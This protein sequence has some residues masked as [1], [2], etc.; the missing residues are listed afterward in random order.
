MIQFL[1]PILLAG[2]AAVVVPVVL[3]LLS[4]SRFR[5]VEWGAMRFLPGGE[6]KRRQ[7]SRLQQWGLLS[8]RI[9]LIGIL[10][11]TLALPVVR[12]GRAPRQPELAEIILDH[13][14]SM[15]LI[16]NDRSRLDRAKEAALNLLAGLG[17]NDRA[18]LI[19]TG[20][21]DDPP[22]RATEDLQSIAQ[23]IS[24]LGLGR[25]IA[26]LNVAL[27]Q[28][29]RLAVADPDRNSKIFIISDRQA[30]SWRGIDNKFAEHWR[31]EFGKSAP[32]PMLWIPVGG[33]GAENVAIDS[34]RLLDPPAIASLP[35]RIEAR[36]HN[37]GKTARGPIHLRLMD[38][39]VQLSQ[40]ELTLEPGESR[41]IMLA[42]RFAKPTPA[43]LAATIDTNDLS[44]DNT[45]KCALQVVPRIP[46]LII[47]GDQKSGA[48]RS[49]ADFLRLALQPFGAAENPKSKTSDAAGNPCVV[50]IIS[51]DQWPTTSLNDYRV[52]VLANVPTFPAEQVRALEQYAYAGGGV[53]IAPGNLVR[54]DD[55][56]QILY[57]NGT[58]ILPAMLQPPTSIDAPPTTLLGI[59]LSH[60]IFRFLRGS[61]DPL[62]Q[63]SIARYFPASPNGGD[64]RVL[65][66]YAT[67]LPFLVEGSF[68][69]GH[70][71]LVTTPLD[72]NWS[73]LPLS[74]FY[75]PFVQSS[76][77]HLCA[78]GMDQY[79][80]SPG[81]IIA[82]S[83][84][85]NAE[86]QSLRITL[87]DGRQDICD[88]SRLMNRLEFR[89]GP[90]NEPGDYVVEVRAANKT[91][92][93]T[94][95][96][97][98]PAGESNLTALNPAQLKQLQTKLNL[99]II[100]P[101]NAGQSIASFREFAIWPWGIAAVLVL[102]GV[103]MTLAGRWGQGRAR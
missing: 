73:N 100:D 65:A 83:F 6:R 79:N 81:K 68:G 44:S 35:V 98:R 28:A 103:E 75:L 20:G 67:G 97:H 10:A 55:Y 45:R 3:H 14:A 86:E 31:R 2:L 4:R 80:L 23:Q 29:A 15:G 12:A 96:V 13:S 95:V 101:E 72:A 24:A 37:Y 1:N 92:N 52:V 42:A 34:L 89:Y 59:D 58:G 40:A 78:A 27:N 53:I 19:T 64:V 51:A 102:A 99:R 7:A 25:S 11:L 82:G 94:F 88:I 18:A 77:K 93:A 49:E 66:S 61:P 41:A 85:E 32:S 48:F 87:P 26:R 76:V 57:R 69:H 38:D 60:P 90:V 17:K 43:M 22:A 5:T 54:A 8:L 21:G 39:Q 71:L 56:N 62:P 50:R 47:S 74:N 36:V 46:V 16:E 30:R 84:P 70:V 63:A 33:P 9:G 91:E